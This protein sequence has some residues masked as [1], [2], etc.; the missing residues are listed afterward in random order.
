[1]LAN[2]G[3]FAV[4]AEEEDNEEE[5][6]EANDQVLGE[7]DHEVGGGDGDALPRIIARETADDHFDVIASKEEPNTSSAV[8]EDV[9]QAAST[10]LPDQADEQVEKSIITEATES[11]Q[12]STV[13]EEKADDVMSH[14]EDEVGE[15][16]KEEDSSNVVEKSVAEMTNGGEDSAVVEVKQE[17]EEAAAPQAVETE[18]SQATSSLAE[19]ETVDTGVKEDVAPEVVPLEVGNVLKESEVVE[20]AGKESE[21]APK[22]EVETRGA[23]SSLLEELRKLSASRPLREQSAVSSSEEIEPAIVTET[24]PADESSQSLV[25]D[26]E[27]ESTV[28]EPKYSASNSLLAE[29]KK[30][31]DAKLQREA[32]EVDAKNAEETTLATSE[33][34]GEQADSNVSK[35]LVVD[36]KVVDAGE[37]VTEESLDELKELT[38]GFHMQGRSESDASEVQSALATSSVSAEKDSTDSTSVAVSEK[39]S[40]GVAEVRIMEETKAEETADSA[41]LKEELSK[42]DVEGPAAVPNPAKLFSALSAVDNE[43]SALKSGNGDVAETENVQVKPRSFS[44]ADFTGDDSDADAEDE[45]D[46]NDDDDDDDE[47]E[48]DMDTAK[49]LA[50]LANAVGKSGNSCL[51]TCTQYRG[52]TC[53]LYLLSM[54]VDMAEISY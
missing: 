4:T 32:S 51:S 1:M 37:G 36:Q 11:T 17:E 6:E 46:E 26:K 23:S 12:S 41:A 38:Y 15:V 22:T 48:T 33:G 54:C 19:P 8:E 35:E 39:L 16:V 27:E 45:D 44:A 47:D 24:P 29:L 20:T 10:P 30:L 52:S 40:P 25:G 28:S 34:S 13:A 5:Y 49:A 18:L 42:E 9:E 3:Y 43:L 14:A 50:E 7:E 21:Q 53:L 31:S 2:V